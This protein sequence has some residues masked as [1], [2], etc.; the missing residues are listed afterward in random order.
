MVDM[1]LNALDEAEARG[2]LPPLEEETGGPEPERIAVLRNRLY[3]MGYLAR[4]SG[5][6]FP[7]EDMNEG[8]VLFAEE[9]SIPQGANLFEEAWTVLQELVSFE[10]ETNLITW[11]QSGRETLL[12]RAVHLRLF[13][14][15]LM[16]RPPKQ[17]RL[18]R[19]LDKALRNFSTVAKVFSLTR[20][21]LPAEPVGKTLAVLFDQ[22]GL[23]SRF[24]EMG[25]RLL[26]HFPVGISRREKLA[27]KSLA[28][29][30][31]KSLARIELWLLGYKTHA[32]PS[33]PNR[34]EHARLSLRAALPAFWKDQD[35][36][37]RPPQRERDRID[38]RLFR[39]MAQL[40][41][42]GD[43][44]SEPED[45]EELISRV[46]DEPN[47][48]KEV[49]KQMRSLGARL[50]DGI[51]R[52]WRTIKNFFRRAVRAVKTF[53]VNTARFLKER[54]RQTAE[55]V[56]NAFRA[57]GSGVRF[58]VRRVFAGSDPGHIM[59]VHDRDLDF[60]AFVDHRADW[61]RVRASSRRLI[62][63]AR[64]MTYG[65]N[66]LSALIGAFFAVIKRAL[67]GW[68]G[69]LLALVRIGRSVA[70]IIRDAAAAG[71]L[72]DRLEEIELPQPALEEV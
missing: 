12:K 33:E 65:L 70:R 64:I 58:I 20:E 19:N 44:S 45:E 10:T 34:F 72:F 25:D 56:R 28:M 31:V 1:L 3:L 43:A 62:L 51:K 32:S 69:I 14:F 54:A 63:R 42:P 41:D 47:T 67:T 38:G 27:W 49:I 8:L 22:E 30:F 2:V 40:R 52:V 59:F 6:T 50:Y 5:K 26:L 15:G 17:R 9:A 23:V 29:T 60:E 7:D 61:S 35:K 46:L 13:A 39:R 21:E 4:D 48:Q 16:E 71:L 57:I 55:Q 66:I 24:A 53:I 36:E 11:L 68:F 18:F 37:F